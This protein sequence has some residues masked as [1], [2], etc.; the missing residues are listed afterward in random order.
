MQII[1][2][3]FFCFVNELSIFDISTLCT[4]EPQKNSL[5][6]KNKTINTIKKAINEI[7]IQINASSFNDIMFSLFTIKV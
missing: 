6:P 3:V 4:V 7:Y 2:L 5:L 1:H